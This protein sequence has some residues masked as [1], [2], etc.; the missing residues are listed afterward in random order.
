VRLYTISGYRWTDRDPGIIAAANKL[1]STTVIV[2]KRH[3][4]SGW[5]HRFRSVARAHPEA[6]AYVF[7]PQFADGGI[8]FATP[9]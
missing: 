2:R 1:R 8:D 4:A 5:P 9:V 3:P 6:F 7:D